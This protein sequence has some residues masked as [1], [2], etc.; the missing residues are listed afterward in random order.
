MDAKIKIVEQIVYISRGKSITEIQ[1]EIDHLLDVGLKAIR[2]N[3][4]PKIAIAAYVELLEEH[5]ATI[6][7]IIES[8]LNKRLNQT[9]TQKVFYPLSEW[10]TYQTIKG[11]VSFGKAYS[12]VDC[13]NWE[14]K[15]VDFIDFALNNSHQHN[16][17]TKPL[18]GTEGL[19]NLIPLNQEY[20]WMVMSLNAPVFVSGVQSIAQLNEIVTCADIYGVIIDA[21]V[22]SQPL[23]K[24]L[25]NSIK[26]LLVQVQE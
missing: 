24:N 20:G 13:K 11:Q 5:C 25:I 8:T 23:S 18:L 16:A 4:Q 22:F 12:I 2:L 1:A 7:F 21:S 15:G 17:F 9:I 19:S 26:E 6:D 14:V 3:N 10:D